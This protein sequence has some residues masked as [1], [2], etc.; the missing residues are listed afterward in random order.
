MKS[1]VKALIV[2]SLLSLAF[3]GAAGILFVTKMIDWHSGSSDYVYL[4]FNEFRL[5]IVCALILCGFLCLIGVLVNGIRA[6]NHSSDEIVD[7]QETE[8]TVILDLQQRVKA[9]EQTVPAN[10]FYARRDA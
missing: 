6:I 5:L 3:Y 1:H 2:W 8:A 7:R 4:A 9:L 10:E